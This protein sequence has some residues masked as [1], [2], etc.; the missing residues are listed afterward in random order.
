MSN[1]YTYCTNCVNSTA[2]KIDAM[3]ETAKQICYNTFIRAVSATEVAKIF[4]SYQ[5]GRGNNLRL[6]NDWA[7]S[8][9]KGEYENKTVYIIMHSCI[10]YIFT[11]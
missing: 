4:P 5:W 11:E 10:E 7:V 1:S 9:Y 8:F 2:E 3:M 6:K